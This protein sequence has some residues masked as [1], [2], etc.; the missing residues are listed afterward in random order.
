[1]M[2]V[3]EVYNHEL[4]LIS[5]TIEK[6]ELF[7]DIKVEV[8]E[9]VLCKINSVGSS[10]FYNAQV[11]NLKPEIKFIIHSFEYNKQAVVEYEGLKYMV[12]RTFVG[13]TLN[14]TVN[15]SDNALKMEEIELTCERVLADG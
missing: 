1:M 4:T 12:I 9:K 8:R 11:S 3:V 6:D 14:R 5:Y 2:V 15:R 13:D 10:E 7:Q